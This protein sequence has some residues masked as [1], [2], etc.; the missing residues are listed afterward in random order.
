LEKVVERIVLMPQ[1]HQV[2][3]HIIDVQ[4]EAN[5]GVATDVEFNEHQA[6][7][8]KIYKNLKKNSENLVGELKSIKRSNP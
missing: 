1:I 3:Q 2:T 7:Y 8:N 5:P 6:Q 4:E